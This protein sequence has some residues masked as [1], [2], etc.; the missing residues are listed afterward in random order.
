[1]AWKKHVSGDTIPLTRVCSKCLEEK[2]LLV[3]FHKQAHGK[4]GR[5]AVCRICVNAQNVEWR[6]VPENIEKYRQYVATFR[7]KPGYRERQRACVKKYRDMPKSLWY[8]YKLGAEKRS[9]PFEFTPEQFE[10]TFWQKPCSYCG[11]SIRTIG[12]DRV[13]NALGYTRENT[14][15]CCSVCNFMKLKASKSDFVAKCAQIA[16]HCGALKGNES[17]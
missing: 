13:D 4:Y 5:Q 12:V 17:T 7:S 15:P 16:K 9:L 1:M 6:K 2:V 11:D 10:E 3:D 8:T 14:V